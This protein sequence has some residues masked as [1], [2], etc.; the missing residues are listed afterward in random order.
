MDYFCLVEMTPPPHDQID[1]HQLGELARSVD[2]VNVY[3]PYNVS[4]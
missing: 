1:F 2:M 4:G 3:A